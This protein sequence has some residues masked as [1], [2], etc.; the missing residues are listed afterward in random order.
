MTVSFEQIPSDIRTPGIFVEIDETGAIEGGGVRPHTILAIGYRLSTG[1]V[2]ANIPKGVTSNE[3]AEGFFGQASQLANI[4]KAVRNANPRTALTAIGVDEAAGTPA[5]G[6]FTITGTATAAGT[7]Q[8][9]IAGKRYSVGVSNGATATTVGGDLATAVNADVQADYTAANASGVVTVTYRHDGPEGN[10][11]DLQMNFRDQDVTPLGLTVVVAGMASG[12]TSPVLTNTLA[13]LAGTAYDTIVSGIADDANIVLIEDELETRWGPMVDLD[14]HAFFGFCGDF[15]ATK[16]FTDQATSPVRNSKQST[17]ACG[18]DSPTPPWIVAANMAGIDAFETVQDPARGRT[19]LV[20]PDVV[21]PKAGNRFT[22]NERDLLLHNG[23]ATTEVNAS[24]QVAIERIT[25]TYQKNSQGIPDPTWLDLT[26]K[27]TVSFLRWSWK[28]RMLLKYPRHK[29]ANDGTKFDPGQKIVTP[30]TIRAEAISWFQDMEFA[31]LVENLD[32][33]RQDLVVQRSTSDFNRLDSIL[34]PD[35]INK[36]V[37]G[38]T[39][40]QPKL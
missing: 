40:L 21:A 7:L 12:A 8:A 37:V 16:D 17:I 1:T 9:Y 36:F 22:Q 10:D 30:S 31:G 6:T 13:A 14:G 38:A 24:G 35:I 39:R 5:T 25:T 26:T 4:V 2:A 28:A 20:L 32:Q 15:S 11:I 27:R 33:F 34:R 3:Q 18:G 23:G 19:T 29:L